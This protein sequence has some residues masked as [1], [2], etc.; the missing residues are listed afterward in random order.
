[1]KRHFILSIVLLI[2]LILGCKKEDVTSEKEKY[3]M[4]YSVILEG[5]NTVTS[6]SLYTY[7]YYPDEDISF[8]MTA[9]K[10]RHDWNIGTVYYLYPFDS[11]GI[12]TDLKVYKGCERYMSVRF[13]FNEDKDTITYRDYNFDIDTILS[14][15]DSKLIIV[16][17]K[18][19][20]KYNYIEHSYIGLKK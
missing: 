13:W 6:V 3:D 18:D 9:G 2:L 11:I 15:A 20:A 16:W 8:Y 4:I 5:D 7:T 10:Q 19:S 17:P 14:I 1:M 12:K